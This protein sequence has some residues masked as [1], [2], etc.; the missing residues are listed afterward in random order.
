MK[1]KSIRCVKFFLALLNI[2]FILFGLFL[3]AM[4]VIDMRER[5]SK[6]EKQTA[7]SRGVLAFLTTL[8]LSLVVT[9]VLGC[10]GALREHVKILYVYA[11]FLIFLVSVDL[12]VAAGGAL[13]NNWVSGP[14]KLRAHFYT[15]STVD[16]ERPSHLIYWDTLQAENKCCGVDGPEDYSLLQRDIPTSCCARA[17]P[18]RE[19]DARRHFHSECLNNKSY[20]LRGCEE[21]LKQKLALTGKIFISTGAL[22]LL[23]EITSVILALWM[24]RTVRTERRRLQET[25]QAHFET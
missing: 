5:K 12:V 7:L 2:I 24:A 14:S 13:L 20:Y 16:D 3:M 4:C 1:P 8:A 6:P 25:L 11:C 17:H 19:G 9:A 22:F 23:L 15:N 21:I 10:I 18:L